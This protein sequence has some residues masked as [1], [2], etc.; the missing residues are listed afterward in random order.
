MKSKDK[1]PIQVALYG[2]DERTYKT[3]VM[4]LHGP[5]KE[6][7]VVVDETEA[8]IDLIDADYI[9]ARDVLDE[10][11][12]KTPERPIILLSLQELSLPG[13]IYVKKPVQSPDLIAALK[14][15]NEILHGGKP[16]KG[17]DLEK[18]DAESEIEPESAPEDKTGSIVEKAPADK[19]LVDKEQ[20]KPRK[21]RTARDLTEVGFSAYMGHVNGVD[22][23]DPEQ[24]LL[25][26]YNP[27][28]HFLGYVK[29]AI[30]VAKEKSR[31]LQLNSGWK[32]LVIF[33]HS[34]EIWLDADDKQLRIYA[35]LA[36]KKSAKN[37]MSLSPIE[38]NAFN[39]SEKMEN[40]DD[41]DAFIWKLAIWTSKGQ[42][43]VSIDINRPVYLKQWPNFTRL[44]VTPHAMR[45][46]ALL[47][48]GPRSAM[49]VA[50]ALNIKP[51]YVF[52]F[53]S[54]AKTLGLLGQAKRNADILTV[55]PEVKPSKSKGILSR[56]LGRLRGE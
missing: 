12:S 5:C 56:I 29:T 20:Q 41:I 44:I 13:T 46:A 30:K 38:Q 55:P 7:A 27:K 31:I 39:F 14:Q 17:N 23:T 42:Y 32:S 51:Q 52:V 21:H 4:F 49:N 8:E 54:A 40:F 9:K 2:M 3:M 10:R 48:D 18:E 1:K 24:V 26:S 37:S 22:F 47:I 16:K 6:I 50:D 45:I 15:G 28:S 43:P 25:A 19:K 33:P 53:I 11:Q 35:G 36:I 34:N